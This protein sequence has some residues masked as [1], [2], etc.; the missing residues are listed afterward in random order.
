LDLQILLNLDD[1][2]LKSLCSVNQYTRDLCQ[3]DYFWIQKIEQLGFDKNTSDIDNVNY[4]KL[5]YSMVKTQKE[6]SI[7]K[8]GDPCW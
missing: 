3:Q 1:P 8:R 4:K 6:M 7:L 2:S 5:Y